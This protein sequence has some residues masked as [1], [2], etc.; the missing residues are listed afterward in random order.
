SLDDHRAGHLF[1]FPCTNPHRTL[2]PRTL[3]GRFDVAI[4]LFVA[5]PFE[6]NEVTL[7]PLPQYSQVL[8][9]H[10]AP[11]TDKDHPPQPEAFLQIFEQ[12]LNGCR[13][14]Q[15]ALEDLMGNRPAVDHHQAHLHLAIARLAIATVSKLSKTCWPAPLKIGAR[16]VIEDKLD[17]EVEQV[18]QPSKEFDLNTVF[19]RQQLVQRAIPFLKPVQVYPYPTL[20]LPGSQNPLAIT[21]TDKIALQPL[22][23][24]VLAAGTAETTGHQ[25]QYSIGQRE[26]PG[27]L[28]TFC[29]RCQGIKNALQAQFAP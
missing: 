22:R 2:L 17:L 20:L 29:F 24:R 11:V 23:Q 9:C 4:D 8:D 28:R 1:F 27:L 6:P 16:Q 12:H 18:A 26:L 14:A 15:A 19:A 3:C 7:S 10:H 25:H 21:S 5:S 13:I